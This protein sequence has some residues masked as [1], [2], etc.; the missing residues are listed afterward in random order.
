MTDPQGGDPPNENIF[1]YLSRL[2]DVIGDFPLLSWLTVSRL[3][4]ILGITSGGGGLTVLALQGN[5]DTEMANYKEEKINIE[6]A[7]SEEYMQAWGRNKLKQQY[8]EEL[9]VPPE[10][11]NIIQNVTAELSNQNEIWP[12]Y[13]W[14]CLYSSEDYVSQ[15]IGLD[16]KRYCEDQ[17]NEKESYSFGYKN[18]LDPHSFVCT[19]VDNEANK[20]LSNII[21]TQ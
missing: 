4:I 14:R 11:E 15:P 1:K 20:P 6:S 13:R 5:E 18:Y 2:F 12:V 7:C 19:R 16:L 9:E 21:D 3:L 17:A 8:E 10:P